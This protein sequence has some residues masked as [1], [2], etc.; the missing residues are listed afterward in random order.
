MAVCQMR[1]N[2]EKTKI[3]FCKRYKKTVAGKTVKFDFLCFSFQPRPNVMK[4]GGM[5]LGYD[6]AWV[7]C[8][9]RKRKHKKFSIKRDENG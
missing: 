5:F 6:C 3:V 9:S 4:K 7:C 2:E 1:I 8:N